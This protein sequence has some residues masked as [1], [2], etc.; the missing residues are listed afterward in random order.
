MPRW[1]AGVIFDFD[2]VLVNSEPLHY[3]AFHEVLGKEG[4]ELTEAEYYNEMIGFDDRGAFNHI[5]KTHD[6]ALDPK[7]FLR[8]MTLKSEK[9]RELIEGRRDLALPG[10]EE[11]VRGLWRNYPLAVC[12]GALR[13]EI[14]LMLE[15]AAL[16]DCFSVIVAAEDVTVG[17]P[18][19]Q[20]YLLTTKLISEKIKRPVKPSDFLIVED[21]PTVIKSVRKA[22]FPTLGVATTY[23]IEKLSD[24]NWAVPSLRPDDVLKVLPDLNILR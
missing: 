23:S 15:A 9:M 4:I 14:E 18:D 22:G 11:F 2:G 1:P 16:R 13:E 17:K 6:R 19:P 24:A 20:G 10:A 5:F 7:T 8:V 12:S 21:A 3:L